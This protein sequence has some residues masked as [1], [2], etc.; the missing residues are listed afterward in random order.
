MATQRDRRGEGERNEA[1]SRA[2]ARANR[3]NARRST[4]PRTGA[5]KGVAAR[6]A[7]VHGLYCRDLV[8]PGESRR[9]FLALRL[10]L[11]VDLRAADA[12]EFAVV[13]RAVAAQWLLR[14]AQAADAELH[15]AA[16]RRARGR[17]HGRALR[18]RREMGDF[19]DPRPDVLAAH[20]ATMLARIDACDALAGVDVPAASA[21]ALDFADGPGG[22]LER[23]A[24]HGHRLEQQF[25]R[26]LRELRAYR[27]DAGGGGGGGGGA[28]ADAAPYVD[29]G[30]WTEELLACAAE[31]EQAAA[32]ARARDEAL[33]GHDDGDDD[34]DGSGD[35]NRGDDGGEEDAGP[36]GVVTSDVD[37]LGRVVTTASRRTS[38]TPQHAPHDANV[39]NE[40]NSS[41]TVTGD[42]AGAGCARGSRTVEV[43]TPTKLAPGGASGAPRDEREGAERR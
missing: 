43:V 25:Y 17:A 31:E 15:A 42:A 20:N 32:A 4:G 8:L 40:P 41:E 27:K 13:E 1:A 38:G 3:R 7:L 33:W 30:Q 36:A 12:V 26:A 28:N 21:L 9:D 16:A 35:G 23:L 29:V 18:L 10:A 19:W 39:Q 22:P 6:N 11:H 14:R 37:E 5:G 34:G 24:R 2:Q